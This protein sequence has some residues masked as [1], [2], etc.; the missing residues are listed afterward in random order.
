MKKIELLFKNLLLN[1]LLIFKPTP[2]SGKAALFDEHSKIMFI[3][4]NRIGDALVSTPLLHFIK[5]ELNCKI[6]VLA[7]VKNFFVFR[8]NSDIDEAI[9][10]KKG[11]KGFREFF[12]LIKKEKIDTIVDL[13]DDISTTV[14]YLIAL[15]SSGNK[16]G[17]EKA[18]KKIY[19]K[20]VPRLDP[21]NVH[22]VNRI[23]QLSRLFNLDPEQADL[24]IRYFPK[25]DSKEKAVEFISEIFT[26]G[27]P[28]LGIN[29][30]A[31]SDAR[32]WG[33]DRYK[34][35]INSLISYDI[36]ILILAAPK[37]R[38]KIGLIGYPKYYL[39]ESF[40][41]FASVISRLKMLLSPD[42]A[43]IHIASAFNVPVF[44]IF[45]HDTEDMIWSPINVNFDYVETTEHNFKNLEFEDLVKKFKP[46]LEK[47]IK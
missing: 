4:L 16:F 23:M 38:D 33:I 31:G 24:C 25:S 29:I 37:D 5:Q 47:H 17:L 28:I 41:E 15:S 22:V 11:L 21:N 34:Q 9:I 27:K 43:A 39:S 2:E 19:T 45:V 30:S 6:Y 12:R 7:D 13:H 18:N 36:E 42:T 1:I 14:S 32:F 46:F 3:R 8:N 26:K 10:F 20:T 40:D 35:L 44:G